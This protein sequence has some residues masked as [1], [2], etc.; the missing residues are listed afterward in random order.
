M[1]NRQYFR[2]DN[3]LALFILYSMPSV[4]ITGANRGIGLGLAQKFI[5]NDYKVIALCRQASSELKSSGARIFENVDVRDAE[6]LQK[7][8]KE[9]SSEKLD[10]LINNAGILRSESLQ[11]LDFNTIREQ[12][13]VN[14]L[15]PLMVSTTLLPLLG[16]SSRIIMITSRM[17]SIAD[18][19]SGSYYGYRMSK[20]ALNMAA[21]S[22][23]RDLKVQGISVGI[24]HP[25]MVNTEM[26]GGSGG[27][28]VSESVAGLYDQ[29]LKVGPDRTG[30]FYH[31]N[32]ESLPW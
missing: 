9:L 14:S 30:L 8:Q 10:I 23:A 28:P 7:V 12:L 5:Q 19:G 20:A 17:G 22:L 25:G 3:M 16:K 18:N 27:I 26:I 4:L 32:G 11:N 13:E 2:V 24:L 6:A 29:I 15:A 1:N 31:Q 21:V